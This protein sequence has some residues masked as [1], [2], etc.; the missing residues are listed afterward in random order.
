MTRDKIEQAARDIADNPVIRIIER[1][2]IGALIFLMSVVWTQLQDVDKKV[3]D[4]RTIAAVIDARLNHLE[5]EI[6]RVENGNRK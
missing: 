4:L 1:L 3:D 2:G 6:R 5:T